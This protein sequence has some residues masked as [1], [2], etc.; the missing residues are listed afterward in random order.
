MKENQLLSDMSIRMST[1]QFQLNEEERKQDEQLEVL[2]MKIEKRNLLLKPLKKKKIMLIS[3][4]PLLLCVILQGIFS[5]PLPLYLTLVGS[6]MLYGFVFELPTILAKNTKEIKKVKEGKTRQQLQE[7]LLS[8]EIEQEQLRLLRK[9]NQAA[10]KQLDVT[11]NVVDIFSK[12]YHL[13]ES[14]LE[15]K[16]NSLETLTM[17]LEQSTTDL[18]EMKEELKQL[19]VRK[20]VQEKIE[21][22]RKNRK[23]GPI[24]QMFLLGAIYG[25]VV[26][27]LFHCMTIG[28]FLGSFFLGHHEWKKSKEE[29]LSLEK[30]Q[31]QYPSVSFETPVYKEDVKDLLAK[32]C[33]KTL[34]VESKK[35]EIEYKVLPATDEFS[36]WLTMSIYTEEPQLE[37]P[38]LRKLR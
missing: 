36:P 11:E 12:R 25:S 34:D 2:R 24:L 8:L 29:S 38:V 33:T 1:T 30:I 28:T 6:S 21:L 19:T 32:L 13:S 15:E 4:I 23:F 16:E 31:E 18:A 9:V 22:V 3:M 7:E 14:K 17:N 27:A 5:F 10:Q 20:I 35:R 26:G 37:G